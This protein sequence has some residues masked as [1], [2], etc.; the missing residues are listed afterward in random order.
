MSRL[1][2]VAGVLWCSAVTAGELHNPAID[3]D[4]FL[5]IAHEALAARATH[6]VSE[7]EFLRMSREGG[8][9]V[10][11][12]RSAEKYAQL[13]VR[14]AVNLSFPDIAPAVLARTIP[15]RATRIL[16]YC[17]NNFRN[18]EGPFPT[19]AASA[20]L[21]LSTYVAL[22]TYGYR[23]VYELGP[24]V[25]LASSKLTFQS[26]LTRAAPRQASATDSAAQP[27]W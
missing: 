25:D 26:S 16:I 21:N 8:T 15:D 4:G 20:S 22:Y 2:A 19:K 7:A 12:A 14:G 3:P 5:A 23:N 10:L 27:H 11:D 9:I 18:A 1:L 17:N 24:L 13:H 6:R